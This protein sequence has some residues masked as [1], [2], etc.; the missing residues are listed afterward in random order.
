MQTADGS[1][2]SDALVM[3]AALH[4]CRFSS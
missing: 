4:P 1:L 2:Q 3:Q